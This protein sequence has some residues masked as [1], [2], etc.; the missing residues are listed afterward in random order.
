M[1]EEDFWRNYFSHVLAVKRSF[2]QAPN[3]LSAPNGSAGAAPSSLA[4][5]PP[6]A[7]RVSYPEKFHLAAKYA[8]EGPPLPNLSDADRI[9]RR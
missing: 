1:S 9:L 6:V 7:A 8:A 5:P 3:G 4:V 2:E